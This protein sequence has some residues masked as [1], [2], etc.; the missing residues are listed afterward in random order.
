[1][2]LEAPAPRAAL[3]A[4]IWSLWH[5]LQQVEDRADQLDQ[6]GKAQLEFRLDARRREDAKALMPP[7]PRKPIAPVFPTPGS[8]SSTRQRAVP[9]AASE[10]TESIR[11]RSGARPSSTRQRYTL[12]IQAERWEDQRF[13]VAPSGGSGSKV[14][15]GL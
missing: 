11:A 15:L 13:S 12:E 3:S 2:A 1:M 8:P 14:L 10:R 9:T 7:T 5:R 4:A 6:P